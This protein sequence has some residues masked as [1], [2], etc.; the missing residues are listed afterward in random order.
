[1]F[2]PDMFGLVIILLIVL[3]VLMIPPGP[4]SPLPSPVARG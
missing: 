1:M 2:D 4:G 3:G